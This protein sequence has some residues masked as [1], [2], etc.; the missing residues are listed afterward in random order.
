MSDKRE[1]SAEVLETG[2]RMVKI[3]PFN[4]TRW[5]KQSLVNALTY[6]EPRPKVTGRGCF[7][8]WSIG[9]AGYNIA[10]TKTRTR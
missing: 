8:I 10:I 3:G 6:G 2:F 9:I 4:L 5:T 1:I 7:I